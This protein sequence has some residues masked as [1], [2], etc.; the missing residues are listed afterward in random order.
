MKKQILPEAA[1]AESSFWEMVF[2]SAFLREVNELEADR[3][4]RMEAAEKARH[5]VQCSECGFPIDQGHT[6]DCHIRFFPVAIID[7]EEPGIHLG[8]GNGDE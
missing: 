3:L 8:T 6:P 1:P 4:E 2:L 5:Q 7:M